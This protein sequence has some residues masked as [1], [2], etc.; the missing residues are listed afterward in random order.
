MS[1]KR[2]LNQDYYK[3]DA[4]YMRKSTELGQSRSISRIKKIQRKR[5]QI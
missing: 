4:K 5:G 3:L 1:K 2:M